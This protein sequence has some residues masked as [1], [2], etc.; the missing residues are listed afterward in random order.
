MPVEVTKN[1]RRRRLMPPG[2]CAPGSFRTK[3]IGK[4]RKL[5]TCCPRGN[6]SHGRCRVGIRGQALLIP[7]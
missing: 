5:V 7:R 3:G 1:Y 6:W 2:K 4:G